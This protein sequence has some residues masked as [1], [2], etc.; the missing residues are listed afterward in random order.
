MYDGVRHVNSFLKI[1]AGAAVLTAVYFVG[2]EMG[3]RP[4][5]VVEKKEAKK[6]KVKKD[7][8][9]ATVLAVSQ[10]SDADIGAYPDCL[11][12][13]SCVR[14]GIWAWRAS[15]LVFLPLL[16]DHERTDAGRIT[17]GMKLQLADVLPYRRSA[18]EN[19]ENAGDQ[20]GG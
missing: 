12:D 13:P 8:H 14:A 3:D 2:F 16:V 17:K 18:C 11:L 1:M 5:P 6:K 20:S 15:T 9:L 4:E 19:S 10:F 7:A